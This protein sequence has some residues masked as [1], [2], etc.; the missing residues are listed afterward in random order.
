MRSYS[1]AGQRRFRISSGTEDYFLGTFYFNRGQYFFPH[2]GVTSLCPP[3][4]PANPPSID[5]APAAD[6]SSKFAAYRLHVGDDPLLFEGGA[7]QTWRN[8]D[9]RGCPWPSSPQSASRAS[10]HATA[11]DL[12]VNASSFALV[13]E[14]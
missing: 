5:C 3:T 6:N 7:M 11:P 4:N 14:W 1:P 12:I 8:G 9:E 10:E 13:Y 2:A